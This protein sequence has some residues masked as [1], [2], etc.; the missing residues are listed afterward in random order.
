MWSALCAEALLE[1]ALV[2]RTASGRASLVLTCKTWK[3]TIE[4]AEARGD[5]LWRAI[6]LYRFPRLE[7]IVSTLGASV[8]FR[9]LYREQL[10]AEA[11]RKPAN[12]TRS[13]KDFAFTIEL[14]QEPGRVLATHTQALPAMPE[15]DGLDFTSAFIP[16][17]ALWSADA[18]PKDV[19]E[20][21]SKFDWDW[22]DS[23]GHEIYADR[24]EALGLHIRLLVSCVTSHG[25]QTVQLYNNGPDPDGGGTDFS[26]VGDGWGGAIDFENAN[27]PVAPPAET[28]R[29]LENR[30]R[31]S[32]TGLEDGGFRIRCM[33]CLETGGRPG[34]SR[35]DRR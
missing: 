8:S 15:D 33:P 14:Y 35:R 27:I 22:N 29:L 6:A 19:V 12:F 25:V 24:L 16:K 5:Q 17:E 26:R 4:R 1:V 18:P 3:L 7:S 2:L 13:L 28:L 10:R 20:L 34:D 23:L 32:R 30:I 11:P 31:D 9:E 21:F